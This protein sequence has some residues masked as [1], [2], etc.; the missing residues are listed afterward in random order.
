MV[1]LLSILP[2]LIFSQ[3]ADHHP[4]EEP[5]RNRDQ[6]RLQPHG[7]RARLLCLSGL[8]SRR[9][10]CGCGFRPRLS[11]CGA[12]LNGGGLLVRRRFQ[13]AGRLALNFPAGK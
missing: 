10:G 9:L 12:L 7:R 3:P 2:L 8:S 4:P 6:D 5:G 1:I 11:G 13:A